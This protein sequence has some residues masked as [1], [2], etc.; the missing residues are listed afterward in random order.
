L[1]AAD[2]LG[3]IGWVDCALLAVLLLSMLL[4]LVR[5]LVFELL[6]LLGW[7]VAWLAALWFAPLAAPHIPVDSAGSELRYAAAFAACFVVALI[8][9]AVLARLVRL[10]VQAT[11][12]SAVDRVL[13]AGFGLLRGAVLLLVLANVVALTSAAQSPKWRNSQGAAWL[14]VA[15]QNLKPLL[16]PQAAHLLPA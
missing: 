1:S 13:G 8:V 2:G 5:G 7:V 10:L 11:P 4:G 14:H 9:W 12:L 6:S 15:M 3:G 16:P